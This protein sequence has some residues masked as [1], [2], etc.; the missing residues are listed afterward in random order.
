[1]REDAVVS[2]R[3]R[4]TGATDDMIAQYERYL[5]SGNRQGQERL[6]WMVRRIQRDR[7]KQDRERLACLDYIIARVEQTQALFAGD[8]K[9]PT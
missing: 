5:E 8:E 6:L 2:R 7:L 9:E 4:E 1:M 3:L